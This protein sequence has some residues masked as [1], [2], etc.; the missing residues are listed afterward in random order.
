[1]FDLSNF[2]A[3]YFL[4]LALSGVVASYAVAKGW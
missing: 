4:A 3:Y 1:M 2:P